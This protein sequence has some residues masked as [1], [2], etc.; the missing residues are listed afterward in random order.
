MRRTTF[1]LS[2]LALILLLTVASVSYWIWHRT[3]TGSV[4]NATQSLCS[5]CAHTVVLS[6]EDFGPPSMSYELQIGNAWNQWKNEGHDLPDDV[7]IKVVVFRGI[8]LEKV[9]KQ[10][11]VLRGKSDY[12]YVEYAL[13]IQFLQAQVKNVES[14]KTGED[15]ES[16][17]KMWDELEQ[18]LK[19]THSVIIE[20]LGA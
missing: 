8:E 13:A 3:G 10:F 17:V 4:V 1:Y 15:I 14:Y 5:P 16:S 7:D 19:K 2:I 20:N 12:R 18:T 9:R 11:P 6:Y